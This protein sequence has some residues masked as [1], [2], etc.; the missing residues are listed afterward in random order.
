M[1]PTRVVVYCDENG[2]VPFIIW[3]LSLPASAQD[4][5]RLRAGRLAE[6]GHEMRRPEADYLR[7][8]IYE[9]RAAVHGVQYRVLYFFYGREAVILT[10]GLTKEQRVPEW[11]IDLA[12]RRKRIFENHPGKHTLKGF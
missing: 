12:L 2:E 1:P 3:L 11:E 8:G 7:D 5:V 10:N 9:L 4:K 6:L